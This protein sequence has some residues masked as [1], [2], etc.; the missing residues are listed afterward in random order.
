MACTVGGRR[1]SSSEAARIA[2]IGLC[3]EC[4]RVAHART[5]VHTGWHLA[6]LGTGPD[7]YRYPNAPPPSGATSQRRQPQRRE[8]LSQ[9]GYGC[10][11]SC[12]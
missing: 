1:Q 10:C 11:C 2:P 4:R 12:C 5:H 3:V 9:N 7:G 8:A 6:G